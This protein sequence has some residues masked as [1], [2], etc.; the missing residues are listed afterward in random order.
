MNVIY[1]YKS[2]L[3]N[4]NYAHN[5]EMKLDG[6]LCDIVSIW[7][8]LMVKSAKEASH[9]KSIIPMPSKEENVCSKQEK[10]T[11]FQILEK[12]KLAFPLLFFKFFLFYF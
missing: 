7:T 9:F 12:T 3:V 8:N 4:S 10:M 6:I 5:S 2:M 1:K 11:L